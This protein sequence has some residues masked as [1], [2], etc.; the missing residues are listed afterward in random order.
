MIKNITLIFSLAILFIISGCS[1]NKS[2]TDNPNAGRYAMDKDKAPTS[3][4]DVS[5]VKDATPQYEA[6]SRGG[7]RKKYTVMGKSYTVLNS[8][9]GY[10]ATGIASWYGLKFHGHLT[11][12]GEVYDMYAMS[13]A[14]KTL[15]LP[16]FVKVTN[17]GNGKTV[18]VRV[19]DRGP[20]HQN[21]LIDLSYA[22]AYKL[23]MLKIGTAKV[24]VEVIYV[25][26]PS[27]LAV[28]DAIHTEQHYIQVFASSDKTKINQ[29]AK[30]LTK[31]YQL[32]SRLQ[33]VDNLYRLQL[34]PIGQQHLATQ[35]TDKLKN[36]GYSNSYLVTE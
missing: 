23:D 15:P 4:P 3:A 19:N 14:H 27:L 30:K 12:N 18:V 25:T 16:S 24:K 31:Q 20:F 36:D 21:R 29:L 6:Y 22:A 10:Q 17:T 13:A 2:N 32:K 7:N 8:G 34:G 5:K 33:T 9:K 11:A 1:S 35:L 26:D 28:N